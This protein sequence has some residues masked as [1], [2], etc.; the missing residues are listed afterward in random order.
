G[1]G[2]Q[3]GE[4]LTDRLTDEA[5]KFIE[6]NQR[7]P[8]FLYLPHYAVH[9]PLMSKDELVEEYGHGPGLNGQSNAVYAAMI[10]SVDESV[11]RIIKKLDEL[12]LSDQTIIVFTS[13]NGG[14]VHFGKPPA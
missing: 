8:F 6:T 13:D 10:Q 1:R 9:A 11:G 14:A 5:L 7:N 12:R 4:Y 2:G 3:K